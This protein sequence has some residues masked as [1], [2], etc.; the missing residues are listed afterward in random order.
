MTLST[1]ACTVEESRRKSEATG[2]LRGAGGTWCPR[3]FV[4]ESVET[5]ERAFDIWPAPWVHSGLDARH[6]Q[7]PHPSITTNSP[8]LD[9]VLV[10]VS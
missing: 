3:S 2:S 1:E 9:A 10:L 5:R 6:R 8:S 7:K 4:S